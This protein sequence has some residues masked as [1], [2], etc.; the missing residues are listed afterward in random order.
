MEQD[1]KESAR[2]QARFKRRNWI[3]DPKF[4]YRLIGT[5]GFFLFLVFLF[6]TGILLF[7]YSQMLNQL[8]VLPLEHR[9]LLTQSIDEL[10]RAA[11]SMMILGFIFISGIFA[12]FMLRL[13]NRI[14]GPLYNLKRTIRHFREVGEY[15]TVNLRK[16]DHSQE[17]MEE[18]NLLMKRL[19]DKD[20]SH[21]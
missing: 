20:Q 19:K 15:K 18:Y 7:C 9:D 6:S 8:Q 3:I 4:Q 16:G 21:D 10:L 1:H 13:S 2:V 14:A 11:N 12:F 5:A 17:L